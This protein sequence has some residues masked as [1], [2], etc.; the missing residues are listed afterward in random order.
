M[1]WVWDGLPGL[2]GHHEMWADEWEE[3]SQALALQH[4]T[5]RLKGV[6]RLTDAL[7]AYSPR[8]KGVH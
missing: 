5:P 8:L 4:L 7:L 2:E 3:A 1:Q 6:H